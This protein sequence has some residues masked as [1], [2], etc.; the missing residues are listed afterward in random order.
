VFVAASAG[1][2]L[3][4]RWGWWL[5]IVIFAANGFGDAVQLATGHVLEGAIGVAVAAAILFYLTRA[6]V[7]QAFS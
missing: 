4:R 5:A 2:L 7:Q 1:C 6:S 3:R